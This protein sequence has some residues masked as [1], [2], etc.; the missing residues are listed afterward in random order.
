ME[1]RTPNAA[2]LCGVLLLAEF[3]KPANFKSFIDSAQWNDVTSYLNTAQSTLR[4]EIAE[5]RQKE[6]DFRKRLAERLRNDFPSNLKA[7]SAAEIEN[8]RRVLKADVCAVDGTLA[9]A[10]LLSGVRSQ[11][12]IVAVNYQN[13]RATHVTYVTEASYWQYDS[14]D[15]VIKTL[16]ER[17]EEKRV[18]SDLVLRATMAYFER[19]Y[20]LQQKAKW[21]IIHGELFPFELRSGLGELKAL[22][23]TIGLFEEMAKDPRI[24][25]VV[26]DATGV[27]RYIGN[28]IPE[29][30]YFIIGD[31]KAEYQTWL[32]DRAHFSESDEKKFQS[33]IDRT[34]GKYYRAVY[35]IGPHPYV[36]F[37]S[38]KHIHE[39]A[40]ILMADASLIPERGFPILVDYAD[41]VCASLFRAGDFE[42]RIQHELALQGDAL[43][44]QS[45]RSHR[46]R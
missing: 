12:G 5:N 28:A 15:D 40:A 46:Q 43:R 6:A 37:A 27:G 20:A 29:Y 7:V 33:F 9:K 8:A 13:D 25:S 35:R 32:N 22:D 41:S 11:I 18:V 34:A 26:S 21:K 44:E 30:H 3:E 17:A 39:F 24:G 38:K 16:Q 45:E 23:V 4:N 14:A 36:F 19:R 31:L 10:T 1:R 42:R 2:L